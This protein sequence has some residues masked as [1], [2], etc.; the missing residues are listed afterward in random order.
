MTAV[1][2]LVAA[3]VGAVVTPLPVLLLRVEA[4]EAMIIIITTTIRVVHRRLSARVG[5]A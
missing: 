2:A 4:A 3:P 5:R 1:M